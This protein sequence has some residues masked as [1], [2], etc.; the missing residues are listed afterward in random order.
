MWRQARRYRFA[1]L[2]IDFV[3]QEGLI[4]CAV[5]FMLSSIKPQCYIA[6]DNSGRL[7]AYMKVFLKYILL[8]KKVQHDSQLILVMLC[9]AM[10]TYFL[11]LCMG[12]PSEISLP[13]YKPDIR[14][15]LGEEGRW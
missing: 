15:N 12:V 11:V 8:T 3:D 7:D 4:L 5:L 2:K 14:T 1:Y 10:G 13:S 9:M 6:I